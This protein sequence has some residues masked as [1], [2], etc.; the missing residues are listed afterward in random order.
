[1]GQT[2]VDKIIKLHAYNAERTARICG[3]QSQALRCDISSSLI[4]VDAEGWDPNNIWKKETY[5][6][7]H[8]M[9][10]VD[11]QHYPMRLGLMM[12][13]NAPAVVFKFWKG[14]QVFLPEIRL[15]IKIR[16]GRE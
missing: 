7:A 13:I 3:Q 1:M 14:F 15:K 2:S 6:W 9:S 16:A 4:V 11:A 12:V 10:K 8:G 5:M